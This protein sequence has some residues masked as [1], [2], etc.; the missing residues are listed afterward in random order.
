[1]ATF[2]MNLKGLAKVTSKGKDYYYVTRGGAR[3]LAPFGTPEFIE[4]FATLRT[5]AS[6]MDRTKFGAWVGLYRGSPD[7]RGGRPYYKLA[8]S[9]KENWGPLLDAA[10]KHF[11]PLPVRL[12]D[13]PAIRK[14][15]RKWLDKWSSTPRTA[16]MAKQALSRVFAFMHAE[17][18]L[19]TNP[20]GG[21]ENRYESGARSDIIWTDPDLELLCSAASPEVAWA[22]RLA[23]LTGLRQGDLL[24][25]EWS[26]VGELAIDLRTSK[27]RGRRSALIPITAELR[28]LLATIPKRAKTVLTNTY[29]KPWKTGF[30]ASWQDAMDR[31]GLGD[32]DLHFHDLRGTA[33][34]KFYRAG[35]TTREI[36][37]I[38]AWSPEHVERLIDMYVKRD[39]LLRDRI[40]RIERIEIENCKTNDK[41]DLNKTA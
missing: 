13:R 28:A 38:L 26:C 14:D 18:V 8:E 4:E 12:F 21:I 33:A 29:G 35:L 19:A 6:N 1:M 32:R 17:G 9:T 20:C 10:Q 23:A 37:D 16:D 7:T 27:S 3:I 15:I 5:P 25:L 39:E 11:G 41:T 22:A 36:A 34:T 24:R 30:G 40:R 31:A 2:K